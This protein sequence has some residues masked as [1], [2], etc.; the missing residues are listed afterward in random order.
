MPGPAQTARIFMPPRNAMQSGRGRTKLWRLEF[1][2]DKAREIEP[3]MGWTS[4]GETRQQV[5]A[6]G[7][8]RLSQ[9]RV[10]H[11]IHTRRP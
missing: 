11:V 2:Q 5:K 8:F 7:D 1:D 10:Q 4:S 9:R 3:L 6:R